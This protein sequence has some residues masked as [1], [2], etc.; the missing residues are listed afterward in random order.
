MES[1]TVCV[2]C[3]RLLTGRQRRFCSRSCKNRD[4]NNRHQNYLSQQA[5]GL[6]RKI[7][8]IAEAGGCCTTC[9]YKRNLA[10]LTWH[11][12]DP[13]RKTFSLDLRSLSNRSH[14]EI[15]AEIEKC[16]LLC[17]NCHAETHFPALSIHEAKP[18]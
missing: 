9:G 17:A 1:E 15:R 6:G 13:S 16:V 7:K 5:R 10:A 2:G 12:K 11:H 14:A 4:T 8:L 3:A 18:I